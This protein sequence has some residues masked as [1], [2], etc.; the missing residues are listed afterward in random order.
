MNTQ[1]EK[2]CAKD[3]KKNDNRK[4]ASTKSDKSKV[5]T[6]KA[7]KAKGAKH[8]YTP[9]VW[10]EGE[11]MIQCGKAVLQLQQSNEEIFKH[12]KTKIRQKEIKNSK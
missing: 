3:Y 10:M 1:D 7:S 9:T 5:I 2:Q 11:K 4:P 8:K 6:N 12:F